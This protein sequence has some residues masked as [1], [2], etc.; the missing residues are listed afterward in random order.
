MLWFWDKKIIDKYG[1]KNLIKNILKFL[2]LPLGGVFAIE[3]QEIVNF[4]KYHG[5]NVGCKFAF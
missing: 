1:Q 4:S 3:Q 5:Y 2:T